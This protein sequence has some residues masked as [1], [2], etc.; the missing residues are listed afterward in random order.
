MLG[1]E[2]FLAGVVETYSK[3]H[4]PDITNEALG[5]ELPALLCGHAKEC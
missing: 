3:E 2:T 5:R 1:I 4:I